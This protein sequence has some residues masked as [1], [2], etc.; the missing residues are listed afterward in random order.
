MTMKSDFYGLADTL[1]AKMTG[2]EV[3]LLNFNGEETDFVR[4]NMSQVRQPGHVQQRYLR[5][6]L[7]DGQR[8][9]SA[10][11]T[12]SGGSECRNGR[13]ESVDLPRSIAV[14]E[15]LRQRLT[16]LPE[17]PHLLY[18]TESTSS[19]TQSD[20]RLP[21]ANEVVDQILRAGIGH[22]LVGILA[23]GSIC[24]GFA[25]SLGQRNWFASHSANFD[26]SFYLR[27]D[28]AVKC[29]YAG[30][31]WKADQFQAKVD[32]ALEQLSVLE[33]EPRTIPPGNYRVFLAPGAL[34]DLVGMLNWGS[35]GLKS[36][37]TKQTSLLR[38]I[39]NKAT[40]DASVTLRDNT[41]DGVTANF[42]S[43]G[44]LKPDHVELISAG[45]HADWLVSPRSAREYGVTANGADDWESASCLELA[46]GTIPQAQILEQLGTGVFINNVWYLNF[47]DRPA[48]RI[49]GMTR[50]ACFWV[51]DGQ[52][53][54]PINVMRFDETLY[55][56]LGENLIGLTQER[57]MI[58]DAGSYSRRA[59]SS[60]RFPGALIDDFHFNL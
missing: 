4:F 25:N 32:G 6:E 34:A 20:H 45:T 30:V 26:W 10:T 19:E 50:F 37:E 9:T 3:L 36:Y 53:V 41:A 42:Q 27:A 15:Q 56:A 21:A 17:D 57:E 18:N 16:E 44:F 22:D 7:I 60:A 49:T 39:T 55:R 5:I 33:R 43:Q 48:C 12:L 2:S 1:C 28:K 8:H 40:L 29:A 46:A 24:A 31:E 59:T 51:E 13:D 35:L 47:S 38:M 52:I 11:L 14:I 23:M 58:L 54:A